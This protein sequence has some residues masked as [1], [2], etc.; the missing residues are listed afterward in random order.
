[1]S[2]GVLRWILTFGVVSTGIHFTHNFVRIEEYPESVI[3]DWVVRTAIVLSWPL[4]VWVA[5]RGYRLFQ[6]RGI[7]AAR[8][9]LLGFGAWALVALGHFTEGNPDVPPVWYATIWTDVL[10]GLLV[11]GF[12]VRASSRA[13]RARPS[14]L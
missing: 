9:W 4:F 5:V 10:A 14:P 6:E 13:S 3:P 8:P 12:V 2:T 11:I 1:M 7:E